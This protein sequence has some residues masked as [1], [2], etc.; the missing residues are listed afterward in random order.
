MKEKGG[1][2]KKI[3][4]TMLFALSTSYALGAQEQEDQKSI[5]EKVR[6][7]QE[8]AEKQ[9]ESGTLVGHTH[10]AVMPRLAK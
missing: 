4:I 8:Q 9:R 7:Q 10:M 2:M 5:E 3:L 6:E 1:S